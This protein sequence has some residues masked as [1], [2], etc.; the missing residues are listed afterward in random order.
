MIFTDY[1]NV[2]GIDMSANQ[3]EI[4]TAYRTLARKWHPDLNPDQDVT[5]IMQLINEAYYILGDTYKRKR[6]DI[7]YLAYQHYRNNSVP[8][9]GYPYQANNNVSTT[10]DYNIKNEQVKS[11]IE[12]ARKKAREYV[13]IFMQ[14]LKENNSKAIRSGGST[15]LTYIIVGVLMSIIAMFT[16]C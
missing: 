2:L 6:Y 3:E 9:N 11:D 5:A 4:K 13:A 12:N 7:E 10:K 14:G 8:E 1:Y 16:H 15:F